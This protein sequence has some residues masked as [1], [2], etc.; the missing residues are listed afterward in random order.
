MVSSEA[1]TPQIY[2]FSH[3]RIYQVSSQNSIQQL[4]QTKGNQILT[5]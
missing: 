1:W 2:L 5:Y 4:N 3:Y